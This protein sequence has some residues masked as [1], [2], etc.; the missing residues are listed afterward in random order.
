MPKYLGAVIIFL[1]FEQ[2]VSLP[3]ILSVQVPLEPFGQE[4]RY[5]AHYCADSAQNYHS[6]SLSD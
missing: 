2:C 3:G 5:D 4:H 1:I 6:D